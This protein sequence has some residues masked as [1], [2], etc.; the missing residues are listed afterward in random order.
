MAVVATE[1]PTYHLGW[2]LRLIHSIFRQRMESV[3]E[4]DSVRRKPLHKY[5]Q[6][7]FIAS[8]GLEAIAKK[9]T[10]KLVAAAEHHLRAQQAMSDKDRGGM[11]I[12]WARPGAAASLDD[13]VASDPRDAVMTD[14]QC[15]P[16]ARESTSRC[17]EVP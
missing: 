7:L 3:R 1:K 15:V 9:N 5:V 13:T 2:M 6:S 17:L 8:Y 14:L 11:L 4:D 12:C 10:V 16:L